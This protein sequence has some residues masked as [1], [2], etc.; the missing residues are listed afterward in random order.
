MHSTPAIILKRDALGR[1]GYSRGQRAALLDE[2]KRSGLKGAAFARLTGLP[3]QTFAAWIQRRRH[4][5]GDYQMAAPASKAS[6]RPVT[7]VRLI[8]AVMAGPG[9]AEADGGPA[10]W[11]ELR[12]GGACCHW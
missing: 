6:R 5:Q 11:V 4:E 8:E 9:H 3:Y 1:I 12:C 2:F 10:L 7:V